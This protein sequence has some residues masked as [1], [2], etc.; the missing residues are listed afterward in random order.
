[1]QCHQKS[2]TDTDWQTYPKLML[3]ESAHTQSF[4]AMDGR[5]VIVQWAP[6]VQNFIVTVGAFRML[7]V[8][9]QIHGV[10]GRGRFTTNLYP[11]AHLLC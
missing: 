10:R 11:Q 8:E 9:V 7:Y 3:K 1:M 5:D 6:S 4:W 2:Y